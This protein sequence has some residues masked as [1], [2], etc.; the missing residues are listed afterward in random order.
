M[1]L[2]NRQQRF[3]PGLPFGEYRADG[4]QQLV[5]ANGGRVTEASLEAG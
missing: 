3:T 4:C 5:R 2:Y 1:E